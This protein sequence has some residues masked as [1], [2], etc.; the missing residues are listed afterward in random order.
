[1][2]SD[3]HLLAIVGSLRS[4]SVNRRV[5]ESAV[6]LL[7]VGVTLTELP[8]AAVP[9]FDGDLEAAGDPAAVTALKQA[10]SGSDGLVI[11][12]PEYNIS[13]PAV[14]K[15]TIDWLSRPYGSGAIRAVPTGV[16]AASPGGR[17]G[18][19]VRQHLSDILGVICPG[20]HVETLGLGGV[21]DSLGDAGL[22]GD[23][24]AELERWL[25]GFVRHASAFRDQVAETS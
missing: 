4:A 8:I 3:L 5:M 19:G 20:F 22:G 9:M 13:V 14:V 15:N 6:T 16:V 23:A 1:M 17:G 11:F 25:A 2:S 10:V 21:N 18:A 7:P 12:T 24:A